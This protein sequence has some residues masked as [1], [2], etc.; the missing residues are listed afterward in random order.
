[1][2]TYLV[3]FGQPD[4]RDVSVK[5]R[6][7]SS[8]WLCPTDAERARMLDLSCRLLPVQIALICVMLALA[9]VA[10]PSAGW[11]LLGAVVVSAGALWTLK[12]RAFEHRRPEYLFLAAFSIAEVLVAA[13]IVASG[14]QRGLMVVLLVIPALLA[15]AIWPKR[16][17]VTAGALTAL[18]M[19][20]VAFLIDGRAVLDT[21][22]LVIYPLSILLSILIVAVTAQGAEVASRSTAVSDR[23][24]GLLNRGALLSRAAE[25]AY[26]A[27]LTRQPVALIVGDLDHFKAI[28]DGH[29]HRRGDEVLAAAATRL[30]DALDGVESVYRY[31]G[32]EFVVI[33][34]GATGAVGASTAETL[35]RAIEREPVEGL[36]VTMSV[37]VAALEAGEPFEFE[38][39]FDRADYALYAA[40]AQGRNCVRVG[41]S[42]ADALAPDAA[43][44]QGAMGSLGE[45]DNG[46]PTK[47]RARERPPSD[48]AVAPGL[49]E[50]QDG[51]I[52]PPASRQR[53]EQNGSWL[54]RD[55]AARAHMLDL[56]H[57]IRGMRM[58]VYGIVLLALIAAGPSY[59]WLP[60]APPFLGAVMMAVVID[61]SAGQRRPEFAIGAA[62]VISLVGNAA[63]FLLCHG[64]PYVALPMLAV[65][66][67]AWSPMF[68]ARGVAVAAALDAIL[69]VAA[70]VV[71]GGH[72]T[73]SDPAIVGAP[74]ALLAAVA[75]IGSVLGRSAIDYRGAAVVDQLTGMLNRQALE[76]R[77]AVVTQQSMHAREPVAL[78]VGDID[79]FKQINDHAGHHTGDIVLREIAYRIRKH[80]RAFEAAYRV[81][82]EE[83]VVL[84]TGL[85]A[86]E[87]GEIA[88][89]L[90][91][92][93]SARSI[94]GLAV[95]MSVGVAASA[96]E[97][98]FDYPRVFE[99]ADACL[100]EAKRNGRDRVCMAAEAP[101]E[102]ST[103]AGSERA[104]VAA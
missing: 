49:A 14:G 72:E 86:Q 76:S 7:R 19:V 47:R 31:G 89:R 57:R 43:C 4:P 75:L 34:P 5:Q 58:A 77:I 2:V 100:Y 17:V 83:F 88:E 84:L 50:V 91:Q 36:A 71:I 80:L 48:L 67:F 81:G 93:I 23:L 32:E 82:G 59:G 3:R 78:L 15:A 103:A 70:A 28:N 98:P 92:G 20:V 39:L 40:K 1:V 102:D 35:R 44:G 37:G 8:S 25:L 69:I 38:A 22:P 68:P 51:A 12:A 99:R 90:R 64:T 79:H 29:G 62:I 101:R 6:E 46:G 66:V 104:P 41:A 73:F 45:L 63:G 52:T 10:V 65:P 11:P 30:R 27:A 96:E 13:G 74:L 87:A 85:R 95:T 9:A 33:M 94:E 97:E 54:V 26:Q 16:G 55:D 60:I 61:R 56:L 53:V 24:T 42:A 18:V 21:P